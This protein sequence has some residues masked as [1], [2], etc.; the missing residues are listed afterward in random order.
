MKN[1]RIF[2]LVMAIL[3]VAMVF[4]ACGPKAI[5]ANT[6]IKI[7]DADGNSVAAGIVTVEHAEPTVMMA[8]EQF[9][10]EQDITFKEDSYGNSIVAIG[11]ID[12]SDADSEYYWTFKLNGQT[13]S[14][15]MA[16][17]AVADGDVIDVYCEKNIYANTEPEA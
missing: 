4:A 7:A 2:A 6:T 5:V 14:T 10:V 16:V 9:L 17:Q 13:V 15:G 11:D 12:Y 1:F 3:C 8:I